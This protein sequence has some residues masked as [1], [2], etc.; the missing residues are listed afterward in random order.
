MMTATRTK[1]RTKTGR[2]SFLKR[3]G[4]R[5]EGEEERLLRRRILN[6]SALKCRWN[7]ACRRCRK[8][9]RRRDDDGAEEA[10]RMTGT[11]TR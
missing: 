7:I 10:T 1:K 8:D 11:M 6:R 4:R 3:R 5:K 2:K 9:R